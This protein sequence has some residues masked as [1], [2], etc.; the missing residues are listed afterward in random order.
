[1]KLNKGLDRGYLPPTKYYPSGTGFGPQ[2]CDCRSGFPI[3]GGSYPGNSYPGISYPGNSYPGGSYPGVPG[4]TYGVPG[5]VI[6]GG[7]SISGGF[8]DTV[9][10][11]PRP[12]PAIRPNLIPSG[13]GAFGVSSSYG[14]PSGASYSS[15]GSFGYSSSIGVGTGVGPISGPVP[16]PGKIGP[17]IGFLPGKVAPAV[18]PSFLPG[19]FGPA[20]T[21]IGVASSYTSGGSGAFIDGR[22][23][24]SYNKPAI[25]FP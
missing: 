4:P 24:Y 1:G 11:Y 22:E 3:S 15:K 16:L 12:G 18:G 19:K 23:G 6:S 25:P 8:D 10:V 21:A 2:V 7:G 17:S 9:Q 20:G 13:P 14:V 5:G